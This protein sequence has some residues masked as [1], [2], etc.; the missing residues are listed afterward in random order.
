MSPAIRRR[1]RNRIGRGLTFE[2]VWATIEK[3]AAEAEKRAAEWEA[4]RQ[5]RTTEWEAE[6]QKAAAEWETKLQKEDEQRKKEAAERIAEWEARL[7]KE[8]EQ[9]KKEAAERIAEWEARL[10]KED[11]QRKKEAAEREAERQKAAAER[12]A[13]RQKAAAERE[14][15][16]Q[17]A[18]AEREAR[19]QKE[20]AEAE[21]RAAEREARQ[22]KEAAEAEK[23]AAEW[24]KI[25]RSIKALND[26]MGG[27]HNSFGEIAEYMV[28]PGVVDLFNDI[29]YHITEDVTPNKRIWD[30]NRKKIKAEIDLYMGNGEFII[31]VEVKTSLGEKDIEHHQRRLEIL[32][33]H[34]NKVGDRRKIVGGMAVAVLDEADRKAV[35]DAGFYLLEPSGDMITM[36]VPEDFVPRKW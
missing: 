18:A 29:G 11:E 1:M 24:Q 27:L 35:L 9:R 5:K 34:I 10:Q 2:K 19:Q 33:E 16:R 25:E 30:E 6:R 36:N 3:N 21:I 26:Q 13:E 8:D 17:K 32:R 7:Q 20:A 28:A 12:E 15:E 4:E 14:A 31:A 23:R 22:Q